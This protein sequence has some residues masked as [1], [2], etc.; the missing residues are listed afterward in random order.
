M[1]LLA[2]CWRTMRRPRTISLQTQTKVGPDVEWPGQAGVIVGEE[3]SVSVMV[4]GRL[5]VKIPQ[6]ALLRGL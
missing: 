1:T 3:I 6:A 4:G 2:G 5:E